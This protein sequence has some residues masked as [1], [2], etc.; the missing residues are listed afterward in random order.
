MKT[1]WV[2]L[3]LISILPA[4]AHAYIDPGSGGYL[5]GSAFPMVAGF[6]AV[7]LAFLAHF[8][9]HTIGSFLRRFRYKRGRSPAVLPG[10]A[11]FDESLSGAHLYDASAMAEGY[12]LCDGCLIDREGRTLKEWRNR[13][14]GLLLPDGRYA[15]QASYESRKWGLF[16]WDDKPVWEMDLPIHHDMVLTP[17]GTLLTLTKEMHPYKGREVDFCVIVEFDLEGRE[18]TRWSTW[19]HLQEIQ[20]FHQPLELD[21]P[22]IFFL[23]EPARRKESTPWGGHYD[24]Y[25]LNSIQV[26]PDTPLGKQDARFQSGNW[27][28]SFRHG[29]MMFIL[30]R[31][32]RA[33]VWKCI[34]SDIEGGIEGQ[35]APTLLANGRI[36]LF[37][38]GRYRGGSRVIEIDPVTL[39]IVWEYRADGFYTLSQ[40]YVQRLPNGNTLVTESERGR[41]FEVTPEKRIVWEY[42]HPERQDVSNSQHPES[43]GQRQWIYR[44]AR[45][46]AARVDLFL[47]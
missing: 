47:K 27:L 28:I 6:V 26:L 1:F 23:P 43:Y 33:I 39:K 41:V 42:Y 13:Y 34:A 10:R 30:D 22:K 9:R 37:D 12:N 45:Y 21:R 25:R 24:Y 3:F 38:N 16:T 44:M 20:K 17:H 5:V 36:L 15:A 11:K 46:P 14:L 29:S 4:F 2:F 32:T 8:F 31:E 35:H 40:G 19:D 18:L 7:A